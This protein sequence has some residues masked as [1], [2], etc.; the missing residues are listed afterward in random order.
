MMARVVLAFA[1][2]LFSFAATAAVDYGEVV[3]TLVARGDGLVSRYEPA[4]G[5]EA[6]A[7]FTDLYFKVF[8]AS[9]MEM[10]LGA[11][12]TDRLKR[13]E[14][15][16]GALVGDAMRGRPAAELAA[17]WQ[18]LR[19][20][21]LAARGELAGREASFVAVASQSLLILA[22]EGFEAMLVVAALA[23]YLRRVGA[24]GKTR[25]IYYG[26]AA[27][28]LASAAT[29]AALIGFIRGAGAAR[30]ALEGA[31]LVGAA[32]VLVYVSH[33]LFSKREAARWKE[34]VEG[35]LRDA[36]SRGSLAALAFAAFLAVY[37]E[38]A[39]TVL[40]YNALLAGHP[41]QTGAVAAGIAGGI[42]VLAAIHVLMR[43]ASIR[44]PFGLFFGGTA[45]L[46][47]ALAFVFAGQGV[48]EL[49]GA[50]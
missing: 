43:T 16:F 30:E 6:A 21:L 45:A 15:D 11:A 19:A 14:V 1:C 23:A 18:R 36:L 13:L 17:R 46:L 7:G 48:L 50:G 10:A 40:F 32:A 31:T 25:Q 26:A 4:R 27:G 2:W 44:L 47:Y 22:R 42:G 20:G 5:Q 38:G 12:D 28:L 29:A 35:H 9:G 8:E 41:D 33:W 34:Y 3:D 37:R 39:E 49:Q 24:G